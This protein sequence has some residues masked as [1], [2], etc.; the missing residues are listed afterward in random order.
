MS[1]PPRNVTFAS[2]LT[3]GPVPTGEN[4]NIAPELHLS[5]AAGNGSSNLKYDDGH[6]VF[7][8][9]IRLPSSNA[10][11]IDITPSSGGTLKLKDDGVIQFITPSVQP[12]QPPQVKSTITYGTFTERTGESTTPGGIK[13]SS[14]AEFTIKY[15]NQDT[16][17]R[18]S[19]LYDPNANI[20]YM[21]NALSAICRILKFSTSTETITGDSDWINYFAG[22]NNDLT[23][24]N[25]PPVP[26]S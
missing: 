3:L 20:P 17:V 18:I 16:K 22:L 9:S 2:N 11:E 24:N 15:N 8:S 26:S 1:T 6:L 4:T 19:D 10:A 25:V 23:N 21:T 7:S 13:I 14:D 12:Q 5:D